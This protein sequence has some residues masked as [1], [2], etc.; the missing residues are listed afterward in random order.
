MS[1]YFVPPAPLSCALGSC[2]H[3]GS[4]IV[5]L[6]IV[7]MKA[8]VLASPTNPGLPAAVLVTHRYSVPQDEELGVVIST[9][10]LDRL[11]DRVEG[12]KPGGWGELWLAGLG[13]GVAVATSTAIGALTLPTAPTP[14]IGILWAAAAAGA[15][16]ALLCLAGY[17]TSRRSHTREIT[18]LKKDLARYTP[19]HDGFPGRIH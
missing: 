16:V 18:E 3:C 12:C 15:L 11:I 4:A 9:R 5:I 7:K 8:D 17:L 6:V 10:D 2:G 13:A 14:P 1:R 19:T